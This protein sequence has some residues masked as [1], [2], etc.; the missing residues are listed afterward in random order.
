MRI[1]GKVAD[2]FSIKTGV[3]RGCMIAPLLFNVFFDCVVSQAQ[4]AMAEGCGVKLSYGAN[5]DV[6][7]W[8]T[9]A[10]VPCYHIHLVVCRR[11]GAHSLQG[12]AGRYA[13]CSG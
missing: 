3:R 7:D 10:G 6:F 11:Y 1:G 4:A 8:P 12:G 5:G 2:W 13:P 9:A